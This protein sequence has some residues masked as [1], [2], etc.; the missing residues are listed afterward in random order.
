M[1]RGIGEGQ[2]ASATYNEKKKK[3][4]KKNLPLLHTLKGKGMAYIAAD[5]ELIIQHA[6]DA[7]MSTSVVFDIG[8]LRERTTEQMLKNERDHPGYITKTAQALRD[9]GGSA[10]KTEEPAVAF[11][12][13]YT[14][15][16]NHLRG[17]SW[18]DR[19]QAD[20]AYD[21]A[22]GEI[23]RCSVGTLPPGGVVALEDALR[24]ELREPRFPA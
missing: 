11:K 9:P 14:S 8:K 12:R 21:Y 1:G 22:A 23:Q 3:K 17:C 24:A 2:C 6:L 5:L 19:E 4:K 15:K 10:R 18:S 13:L 7:K 20:Y 16:R